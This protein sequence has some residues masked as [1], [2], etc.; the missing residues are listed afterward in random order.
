MLAVGGNQLEK[1]NFLSKKT[2]KGVR[3]E[4]EDLLKQG[5]MLVV[6]VNADWTD[7]EDRDTSLLV[8]RE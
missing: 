3:K 5:I 7:K 6:L 2:V 4:F 8:S 1:N